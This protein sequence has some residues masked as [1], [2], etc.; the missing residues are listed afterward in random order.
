MNPAEFSE[1]RIAEMVFGVASYYRGERK[2]YLPHTEALAGER[3]KTLE[4]YFSTDVLDRIRTIVLHG[5]RIPPPPFYA[6][7]LKLTGGN[8][9]DFVHMA[10]VT[11]ID[12]IVFHDRIEARAL[13]HGA[14]HAAQIAILGF[15]QYVELYIRGFVKNLSWLAIP[16]EDQAYKLDARFAE[17]P[18]DAFSVDEEIRSWQ[19]LGKYR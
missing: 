10:S 18:G 6:E 2:L 9:P 7:A 16:L 11:F 14:V 1:T 19:R 15:E 3:R 17:A 4:P 8:F 5:A 12:V 13:F